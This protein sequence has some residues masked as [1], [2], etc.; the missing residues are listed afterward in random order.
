MSNQCSIE[1]LN[2]MKSK[3]EQVESDIAEI[4]SEQNFK[5]IKEHVEHL[6]DDTDNLNCIKMWQLKKKLGVRK[7]EAP[8]A[9]KNEQGEL[10][11]NSLKLKELYENTYKKRL[12]HRSMK[13]ELLDMYNLK[14]KL[15]NLR[16]EVSKRIKCENWSE[17]NLL[18]VLRSLK[19]NKSADS[20]GLIYELF[21]P[22]VIGS[23]LFNSL[24][25]LCNN[26]K[27]QLRIP[28]FVTF[29]D[30]TSI[31]KNKGEK[32]DLDNDRGIFGVSKI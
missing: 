21:R 20:H 11:T 29:T 25:M 10:V 23:D 5:T 16:F 9:K 2:V 27:A 19:K 24:L 30:I 14:M 12:E 18:K 31:Y 22:E 17:D 3:L 28:K 6:V 32:S 26:V 1:E 13:P 15:F 4:H 8:V 7:K